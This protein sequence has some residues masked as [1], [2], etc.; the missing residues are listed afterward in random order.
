MSKTE[1]I[2]VRVF[3]WNEAEAR[4][5]AVRERVF[6]VEQGVPAELERDES[7]A[8]CEHA[9]AELPD[10]RV[11]GTGRLLPDG[12]IG[13]MAV[14]AEWRGRGVGGVLLRALIERARERGMAEVML[15]AQ[16]HA[17]GF[18]ARHGFVAEGGVFL[19]AGIEHRA[20]RLRLGA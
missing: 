19:D 20:M 18:Y 16:V 1:Q 9:L 11:V 3:G 17:L 14:D 5:M 12:H 13:R 8:V 15:N 6:I 7:D 10:G 4:A 2:A